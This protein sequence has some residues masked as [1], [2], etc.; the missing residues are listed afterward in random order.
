MSPKLRPPMMRWMSWSKKLVT[1][2]SPSPMKKFTVTRPPLP[3]SASFTFG[4]SSSGS[5]TAM[6]SGSVSS[7]RVT[8]YSALRSGTPTRHWPFSSVSTSCLP[9]G[10]S[11]VRWTPSSGSPSS[12]TFPLTR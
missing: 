12:W 9:P 11:M 3:T 6:P 8:V 5:T 4:V 10:P 7:S 1:L 2:R